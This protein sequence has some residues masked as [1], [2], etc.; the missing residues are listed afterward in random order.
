MNKIAIITDSSCCL[1]SKR[2]EEFGVSEIVPMHFRYQDK[3]YDADGDW[4]MMSPKE[5]YDMMRNGALFKSAQ[6]TEKQYYDAFKKYLDLGYD[7]LSISCTSALSASVKESYKARD[8]L[9]KLYPNQ[10]IC[11]VDSANCTFTLS[12]LILEV[13]K[14]IEEGKNLDEILTWIDENKYFFNEIGTV[15][16]LTYLRAAGRVSASAAF[17]GGMLSIKPIVAYDMEG[18]NIAIE[19]VKGRKK[20]FEVIVDYIEKY[21]RLSEKPIIYIAHADC[22]EDAKTMSELIQARFSQKLEFVFDYVEPGVGSS[23]G[24]GTL[25]LAFYGTDELR[26]RNTQ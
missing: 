2:K 25:I 9:S 20:S 10:R 16:K 24:P 12:M 11:C 26:K 5:Y 13:K 7:V 15:D 8:E 19:K 17:F 21:G 18:H 22:L 23:V 14:L 4:K 3:I 1:N 6:I